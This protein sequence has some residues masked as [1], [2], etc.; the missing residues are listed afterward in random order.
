MFTIGKAVLRT[1]PR[2]RYLNHNFENE[3][4][5]EL[6]G[7]MCASQSTKT[8]G[9]E[10]ICYRPEEVSDLRDIPTMGWF[11]VSVLRKQG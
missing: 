7:N 10:Q 8:Y 2:V 3:H 11:M 1:L 5:Y 4:W 6:Q 9:L